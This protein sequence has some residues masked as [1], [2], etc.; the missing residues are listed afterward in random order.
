MTRAILVLFAVAFLAAPAFGKPLCPDKFKIVASCFELHGRLSFT[1]SM[2][3]RIWPVGT[4]RLV[5]IFSADDDPDD[6][7]TPTLVKIFKENDT[8]LVYGDYELCPITHK[9]PR[10]MQFVCLKSVSHLVVVNRL[11]REQ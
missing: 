5:E 9:Q 10:H 2:R 7:L 1:M 6:G 4:H 8:A 11:P 3:W